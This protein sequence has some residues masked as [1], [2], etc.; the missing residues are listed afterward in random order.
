MRYPVRVIVAILLKQTF[1][2]S[3]SSVKLHNNLF[4]NA[5][6]EEA[7][8]PLDNTECYTTSSNE[9]LRGGLLNFPRVICVLYT[10]PHTGTTICKTICIFFLGFISFWDLTFRLYFEVMWPRMND[11]YYK[12]FGIQFKIR[13]KVLLSVLNANKSQLCCVYIV[14]LIF[15]ASCVVNR[16]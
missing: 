7:I 11:F 15:I 9:D 12:P 13:E 10:Y 6:L 8:H 1:V 16:G 5:T 4:P 2:A 14:C 3:I